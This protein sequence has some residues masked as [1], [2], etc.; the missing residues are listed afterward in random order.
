MRVLIV[1]CVALSVC[2][3]VVRMCVSV[4]VCLLVCVL[5]CVCVCVFVC[6]CMCVLLDRTG[7]GVRVEAR[8]Y[9]T[10]AL[11]YRPRLQVLFR[12]IGSPPQPIR[13]M[14]DVSWTMT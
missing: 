6:P 14:L 8:F 7:P 10:S 11:G 12:A 5:V 2:V 13:E 9:V 4:G 1:W 3:C